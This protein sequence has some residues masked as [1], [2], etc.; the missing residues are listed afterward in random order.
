LVEEL[1]KEQIGYSK[2]IETQ[3][4]IKR[5]TKVELFKRTAIAK[6]YILS[7]YH[8]PIHLDTLSRLVQIAPYHFLRTFKY[9]FKETPY[10]LITRLRLS[11]AKKM[12]INTNIS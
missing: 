9:N 12:L 4:A 1:T 11:E 10:K 3:P 5:T 8:Q 7:N 6:D 2:N